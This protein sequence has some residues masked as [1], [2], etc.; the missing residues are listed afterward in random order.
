VGLCTKRPSVAE[1]IILHYYYSPTHDG[2]SASA[3]CAAQSG[4]FSEP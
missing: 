4:A 2:G 1:R 3:H